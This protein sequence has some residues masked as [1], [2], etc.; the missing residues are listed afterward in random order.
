M[1]EAPE[2]VEYER[3]VFATFQEQIEQAEARAPGA[4]AILSLAAF[5][6]PMTYRRSCSPKLLR[7]NRLLWRDL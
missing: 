6:C 2:S 5:M 7:T 1:R 3:A 4:R